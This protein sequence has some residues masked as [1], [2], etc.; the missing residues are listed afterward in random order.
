MKAILAKPHSK[1]AQHSCVPHACHPVSSKE[2]LLAEK[3]IH[4]YLLLYHVVVV[5]MSNTV[6]C[7]HDKV[8]SAL[9]LRHLAVCV[10]FV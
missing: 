10:K 9:V 5:V 8:E 7:Y 2:D 4:G 1:T 3:L 6:R